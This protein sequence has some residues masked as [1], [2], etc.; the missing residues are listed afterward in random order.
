MWKLSRVKDLRHNKAL[1]V[2]CRYGKRMISVEARTRVETKLIFK[3]VFGEL[4]KEKD[5][6]HQKTSKPITS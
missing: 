2:F 1:Q 6:S 3:K 4:K 5:C